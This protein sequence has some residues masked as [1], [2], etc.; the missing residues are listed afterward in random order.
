MKEAK[1]EYPISELIKR[2]W[3]P[4][5]FDVQVIDNEQIMSLFEAAR[6][7]ASAMNEQPWRFVLGKKDENEYYSSIFNC[8]AEGNKVWASACPVLILAV[9]KTEYTQ[10]QKANRTAFF[11]V[12]LAV[13]NLSL[14][15]TEMGLYVH[16]M[17]G[18]DVQEISKTLSIPSNYIPVVVIAVGK[19]ASPDILPNDLKLRELAERPRKNSEEF[20]FESECK[21]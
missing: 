15:A 9:A 13:A 1:N 7:A 5:A 4:R 14:Q 20:V 12:G 18:F 2:R 16:P 10:N 3:S 8:L 6:W 21:W 17:G 19:I 11:D